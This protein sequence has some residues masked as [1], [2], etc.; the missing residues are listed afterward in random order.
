VDKKSDKTFADIEKNQAA[1][2]KSIAQT[3]NLTDESDRLLKQH[4]REIRA[5]RKPGSPDKAEQ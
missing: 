3:K 2:R 4:K 5:E 1:L